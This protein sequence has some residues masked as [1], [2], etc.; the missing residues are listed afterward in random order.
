MQAQ[1]LAAIQ[2]HFQQCKGTITVFSGG[3]DSALVL[4]L[5]RKFLGKEKAIGVISNSAS[6]KEK[7]DFLDYSQLQ[8]LVDLFFGSK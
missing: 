5:S 8:A 7:D 1:R 4:F 3:I 6:L 2:T